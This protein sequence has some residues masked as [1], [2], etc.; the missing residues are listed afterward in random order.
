MQTYF[1]WQMQLFP[2]KV[3]SALMGPPDSLMVPRVNMEI[4]GTDLAVEHSQVA[5]S[6]GGCRFC[7]FSA[8]AELLL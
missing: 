2:C 8:S 5:S 6:R 3:S 7:S 1:C 4:I